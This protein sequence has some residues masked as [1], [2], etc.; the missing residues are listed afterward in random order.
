MN[1]LE[2]KK[3]D[4]QSISLC[5]GGAEDAM[6]AKRTVQLLNVLCL[7]VKILDLNNNLQVQ[8][9]FIPETRM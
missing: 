6:H 4:R 3:R 5:I 9:N 7:N 1:K 8:L 2:N